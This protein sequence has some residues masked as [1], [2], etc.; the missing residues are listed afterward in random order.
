VEIRAQ[1]DDLTELL[2]HGT[3]QDWL[4]R[5]VHGHETFSLIML[6]LDEFKSV[7]DALGH[8][9]GD[10]LL[11]EISRAIEGVVGRDTD[12]VFR[13]GGD[14]FAVIVGAGAKIGSIDRRTPDA[15]AALA[16]A[17]RIR[18]AVHALGDPGS[19]W[20]DA[21]LRVSVSIGLATYPR[22]GLTAD[23]ILL[24]ADRACF[25]AKR[26]GSGLIATAD[27]GLA[28]AREFAFKA[29]TPIDAVDPDAR[30]EA[31]DA[32]AD[33]AAP[34][35]HLAGG[36]GSSVRGARASSRSGRSSRT[37]DASPVP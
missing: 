17:E 31:A 27:E 2:N 32:A 11:A 28:I 19:R 30:P 9:A 6:D 15:A 22:D 3:F 8:Q 24:A 36:I 29:P 26:T 18:A 16:V 4:A 5:S 14:E 21:G 23:E 25:V 12:R 7:N 34:P 33:T 10:R 1:T 13:Y 37:G 35:A 20:A